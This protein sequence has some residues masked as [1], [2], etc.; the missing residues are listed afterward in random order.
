MWSQRLGPELHP[1]AREGELDWGTMGPE[2]GG[3]W[4]LG[5]PK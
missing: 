1:G 5:T 4:A 3:F 2:G